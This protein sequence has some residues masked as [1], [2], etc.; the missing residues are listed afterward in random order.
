MEPTLRAGDVLLVTLDVGRA[1]VDDLVLVRWP[2]HPLSVKRLLQIE[3]DGSWWVVRDS[4]R[5]GIDSFSEGA[6]TPGGQFG[7]VLARI[8]PRPRRFA[9]RPR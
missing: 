1:R 6:V 9:R 7:L 3:G 4:P 8:W 5:A 2:N